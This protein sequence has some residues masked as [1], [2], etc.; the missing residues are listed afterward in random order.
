MPNVAKDRSIDRPTRTWF[1]AE[2]SDTDLMNE[3]NA[4]RCQ[5][6]KPLLELKIRHEDLVLNVLGG[7]GVRGSEAEDVAGLVWFRVCRLAQQGRWDPRRAVYTS[8][9]FVPL[10]K[11]ISKHSALDFQRR[12]R[13]EKRR[14]ARLEQAVQLFGADWRM[15]AV[16]G[17]P[18]RLAERPVACGVP[19]SLASAVAILPKDL[20]LAYE[21]HAE[22]LGCRAIG[23]RLRCS[24]ATASRRVKRARERIKATSHVPADDT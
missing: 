9:S 5:N 2:L 16:R 22:G 23:E 11:K 13:R 20:R 10:L 21:L 19:Q 4:S 24:P 8:D 14:R 7:R 18:P 3:L 6:D 1:T 15:A 17:R 12:A